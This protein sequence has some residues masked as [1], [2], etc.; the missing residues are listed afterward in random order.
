[1]LSLKETYMSI[2]RKII[3]LLTSLIC[4]ACAMTQPE[5]A[6]PDAALQSAIVAGDCKAVYAFMSDDIKDIFGS[7]DAFCRYFDDNHTQFEVWAARLDGSFAADDYRRFAYI[8]DD[9]QGV[10]RLEFV[11]NTWKFEDDPKTIIFVEPADLRE[12]FYSYLSSRRFLQQLSDFVE[13]TQ[14]DRAHQIMT[15]FRQNTNRDNFTFVG[16]FAVATIGEQL[17]IRFVYRKQGAS[18]G[19]WEI[20]RCHLNL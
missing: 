12:R 20:Y 15:Y 18:Q 7:V 14:P 5:I 10:F 6:R 2:C 17:T 4:C 13:E 11:D 3:Y 19:V 8:S 16:P 9:P 1:M